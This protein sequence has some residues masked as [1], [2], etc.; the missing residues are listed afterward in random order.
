LRSGSR[1]N[2]EDPKL[3]HLMD[4]HQEKA[5]IAR[6]QDGNTEEFAFLVR[7]YQNDIFRYVVNL[8]GVQEVEDV[9]QESFLA[10]FRSISRFDGSRAR[11]RTWLLRIARNRAYNAIKK[12]RL[13]P[14]A[15]FP[16]LADDLNPE[17]LLKRKI[18][19]VRL[20]QALAALSFAHRSVFVLAEIDGLPYE[21]IARIEDIRVGTVK[22]RLARA[23][24]KLKSI[25]Q[26]EEG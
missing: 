23:K 7:A 13:L 5:I 16:D 22:S 18:E 4:E 17:N 1:G 11:F 21:Q 26:N 24:A 12:S 2:K 20:D 14:V 10:A 3:T 15:D 6:V 8:I 9:V 25:L 19:F